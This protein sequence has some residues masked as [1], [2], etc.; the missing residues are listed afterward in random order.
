MHVFVTDINQLFFYCEFGHSF[1][2]MVHVDKR[3]FS[4]RIHSHTATQFST[5]LPIPRSQVLL[6]ILQLISPNS[7][8]KT[9]VLGFFHQQTWIAHFFLEMKDLWR[10]LSSAIRKKIEAAQGTSFLRRLPRL[11]PNFCQNYEAQQFRKTHFPLDG[12]ETT[13]SSIN[14]EVVRSRSCRKSTQW[15]ETLSFL[16]TE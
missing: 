16:L 15:N 8:N 7:L 2:P 13:V 4:K 12:N 3:W 1:H 5:I 10:S 11:S 6:L 14:T 9:Q